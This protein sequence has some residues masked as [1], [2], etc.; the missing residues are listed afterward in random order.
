MK[1]QATPEIICQLHALMNNVC[2]H[3]A[4]EEFD[5]ANRLQEEFYQIEENYDL[6]DKEFEED[7]KIG[8]KEVTGRV[9]VPA[10]YQGFPEV[11]SYTIKRNEPVAALGPEKKFALVTTDGYGTPLTP[12]EY[13]MIEC[14]HHTSFYLCYK[15]TDGKL[16]CGLLSKHGKVLVPCI[17]DTIWDIQNNII[18]VDKDERYGLYT[19][20]GLYIAPIYYEVKVDAGGFLLVRRDNE[21]GYISTQ[22]DFIHENDED[23]LDHA[24]LLAPFPEY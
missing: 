4:Q 15:M 24:T 2:K 17:M 16:T 21:W 13:D 11:Y 7:G 9:I 6:F 3:L 19:T 14:K 22:G 12:F 5:E 18:I 10:L 20:S 23:T 8:L 1:K